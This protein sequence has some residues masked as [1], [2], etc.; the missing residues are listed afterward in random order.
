MKIADLLR[1]EHVVVPLQADTLR[2]AALTL[3]DRLADVGAVEDADKLRARIAEERGEDIVA[4]GDRAFLLHYRTDAAAELVVAIGVSPVPIRREVTESETQEARIVLLI[5][6]PPRLAARYLQLLGA[7]GKLLSTP[8]AVDSILAAN[9]PA[10]L[11]AQSEL[12]QQEIPEHLVVRDIMSEGPRVTGPDTPLRDA[13]R[14]LGRSRVGALPVLDGDGLLIGMLTERE[15]LRHML[16]AAILGGAGHHPPGPALVRRTVRDVMTRQVLAVSPEQPLAEA[17]SLMTNKDV[18]GVPV[19]REGRL[20]GFL[21]R[22]DI[23]RK[24]IG[25]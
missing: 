16:T 20:V 2:A 12:W 5:L 24:L 22:G 15:L 7:L 9:S 3:A 10:E 23:I 11:L 4:L 19:V 14:D 17:A 25:T 1:R 8:A 21:S 6:A 18:E 13:A